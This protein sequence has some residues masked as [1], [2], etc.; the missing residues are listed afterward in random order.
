MDAKT[1][2]VE[3]FELMSKKDNIKNLTAFDINSKP[4]ESYFYKRKIYEELGSNLLYF[5]HYGM[6][7]HSFMTGVRGSGKT[8]TINMLVEEIKNSGKYDFE[9]LYI[10]CKGLKRSYDVITKSLFKG[11]KFRGKDPIYE[12]ANHFAQFG[13]KKFIMIL[14][15]VDNLTDDD[16]LYHI[17]RNPSFKNIQLVM[18]T[19]KPKF[20]EKISED[21]LSSLQLKFFH[22]DSYSKEELYTIL[23]MRAD[24]GL[25]KYN[26][27]LLKKIAEMNV[28]EA[29][30][31]V[32]VG[33][34][35]TKNF[36]LRKDY[37]VVDTFELKKI[38]LKLEIDIAM[39]NIK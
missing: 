26:K 3:N 5:L 4:D 10:N 32:R 17:S 11:N 20:L 16:L 2:I 19:R 18:I 29:Y 37:L 13:D 36:F 6:R 34:T 9:V 38:E 8:T 7:T 22:F 23:S 1:K 28:K 39:Q 25:K 31:D 30:S 14:D 12:A 15:E 35:V 21:V 24:K 27:H 33:M